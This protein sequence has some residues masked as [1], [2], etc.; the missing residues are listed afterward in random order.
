MNHL[1]ENDTNANSGV[2]DVTGAI[3]IAAFIAVQRL[4]WIQVLAPEKKKK[5]RVM[6]NVRVRRTRGC[7]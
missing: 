5:K 1:R 2:I 6:I 3:G 4:R 7:N